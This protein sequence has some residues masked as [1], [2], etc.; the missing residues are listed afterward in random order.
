MAHASNPTA[1]NAAPR[2]MNT[3]TAMG[4]MRVSIP[5]ARSPTVIV[6]HQAIAVVTIDARRTLPN[7]IAGR[8]MRMQLA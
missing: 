1:N 8:S 2:L 3:S 5:R 6:V 7:A 4:I